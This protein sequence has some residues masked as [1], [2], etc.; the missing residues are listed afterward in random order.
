MNYDSDRGIYN[1]QIYSTVI[2]PEILN[3]NSN[4]LNI[5]LRSFMEDEMVMHYCSFLKLVF[6]VIIFLCIQIVS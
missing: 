2:G 6:S 5:S 3:S 4:F 1:Q